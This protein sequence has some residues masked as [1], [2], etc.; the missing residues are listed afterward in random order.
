LLATTEGIVSDPVYTGRALRGLF[1][2]IDKGHFGPDDTVLF[3]HTGG[4][5][6][7]FGRASEL[8][9]P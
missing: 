7:L 3:W 5:S 1:D 6:G 2:L 4:S 8:I 9:E